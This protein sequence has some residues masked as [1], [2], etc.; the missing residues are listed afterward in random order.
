MEVDG[1]PLFGTVKGLPFKGSLHSR[2]GRARLH[3]VE[4]L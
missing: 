2:I 1:A 4:R 3:P